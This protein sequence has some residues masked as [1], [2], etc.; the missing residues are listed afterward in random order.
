[1]FIVPLNSGF[2]GNNEERKGR[3]TLKN[4]D[5]LLCN[6]ENKRFCELFKKLKTFLRQ[7]KDECAKKVIANKKMEKEILSFGARLEQL[8]I[9]G[10]VKKEDTIKYNAWVELWYK[11]CELKDEIKKRRDLESG[12]IEFHTGKILECCFKVLNIGQKGGKLSKALKEQE[13]C[14]KWKGTV[15]ALVLFC[16]SGK[17]NLN[18][19]EK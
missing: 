18:F 13:F 12:V 4:S 8:L 1:M 17:E 5:I 19:N 10:K 9:E 2:A 15:S 16:M 7:P 3:S 14:G 6:E 11:L